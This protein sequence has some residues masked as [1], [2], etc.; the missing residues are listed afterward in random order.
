[1]NALFVGFL[2]YEEFAHENSLLIR[3]L[4]V[5]VTNSDLKINIYEQVELAHTHCT[6]D[7]RFVCFKNESLSYQLQTEHIL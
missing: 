2:S 5:R 1:V 7:T 6:I 3:Y 4:L